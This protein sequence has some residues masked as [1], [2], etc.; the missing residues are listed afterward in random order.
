MAGAVL[1][2]AAIGSAGVAVADP[3]SGSYTATV[4]GSIGNYLNDPAPTWVFTP[5]GPGCVNVDA[6]RAQLHEADGKWTGTFELHATDN[7]EVVVCTRTVT[8][9]LF[10][11][12]ICPKPLSVM[13]N[14]QLTKNG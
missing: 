11:S 9:A 2:T 7:G 5:C 10:A 8:P 13:V 4:T 6:Q 14:Y 12:D 3:L 1:A